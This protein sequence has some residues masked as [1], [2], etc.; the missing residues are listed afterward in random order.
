MENRLPF[1]IRIPR[2]PSDCNAGDQPAAVRPVVDSRNDEP[3]NRQ[4]DDPS[5]DLPVNGPA[6][7]AFDAFSEIQRRAEQAAQAA[8]APMVKLTPAR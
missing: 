6:V 2:E 1:G 8:E 5:A 4:S 3:E 7:R